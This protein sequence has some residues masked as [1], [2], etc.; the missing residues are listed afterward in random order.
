MIELGSV[1]QILYKMSSRVLN[2]I[3]ERSYNHKRLQSEINVAN[4][5]I[6]SLLSIHRYGTHVSREVTA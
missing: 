6:K 2:Q 4:N 1:E 5:D 3:R